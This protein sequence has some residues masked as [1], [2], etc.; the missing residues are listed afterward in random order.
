[1]RIVSAALAAL[2]ALTAVP[3]AAQQD[4]AAAATAQDS[5]P[6]SL[7]GWSLRRTMREFVKAYEP[8]GFFPAR[9]EWSWV[10]TTHYFAAPDRVGEWRF[11]A[12]QTDSAMYEGPLCG[13]F[14]FYTWGMARGEWREEDAERPWRRVG[15]TLRFVPP[16]R[17]ARSPVFVQWRREDGRWV[18][19]AVGVEATHEARV[20]GRFVGEAAPEPWTPLRLPLPAWQPVAADQ[21]WYVNNEPIAVGGHRLVKYGLP[22]ILREED[23]VRWGTLGGVGV[24][25]EPVPASRVTP[26]VVY[27]PVDRMGT[28]QPYQN[29]TDSF[30]AW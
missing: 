28:F 8:R 30:C 6:R 17:G 10:V 23:L 5:A 2:L 14:P 21:P 18:L 27:V 15:A 19:S 3:A 13:E 1:M 11:P 25:V 24:Y 7:P 9:G 4:S 12:A 26:E 22:R 16:G 20:I 29:E